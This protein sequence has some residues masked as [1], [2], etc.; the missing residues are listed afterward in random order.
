MKKDVENCLKDIKKGLSRYNELSDK[1]I[2]NL[3]DTLKQ[4]DNINKVKE[5]GF[6]QYIKVDPPK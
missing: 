5:G 2:D 4:N 1:T 6:S 3:R